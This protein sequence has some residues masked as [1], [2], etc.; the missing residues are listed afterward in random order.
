MYS[1]VFTHQIGA[2]ALENIQTYYNADDRLAYIEATDAGLAEAYHDMIDSGECVSILYG[3]DGLI[4]DTFAQDGGY[5]MAPLIKINSC[6]GA[7]W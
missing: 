1:Q 2:S 3:V 4:L 6:P 7:M 5:W